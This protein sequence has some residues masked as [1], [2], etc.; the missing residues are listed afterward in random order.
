MQFEFERSVSADG[1]DPWDVSSAGITVPSP[2]HACA[3]VRAMFDT[4]E[5]LSER[6][7]AHR[8]VALDADHLE[9][10][11]LVIAASRAER[12]AIARMLPS[13]RDRT[14]TLREAIALSRD[15]LAEVDDVADLALQMNV[16]RGRGM[17]DTARKPRW[18]L[19]RTHPLDI[20]DA[21]TS[22]AVRHS[23]MLISARRHVRAL[24]WQLRHALTS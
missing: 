4:D 10:Y 17:V 13:A 20:P 23:A 1:D 6:I 2:R 22:S 5:A 9:L 19:S 12:A 18:S 24:Q 8:S 3:T 15:P 16:R 21:H 7:A 11:P 14:F